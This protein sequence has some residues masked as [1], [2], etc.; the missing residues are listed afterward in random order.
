MNRG[1]LRPVPFALALVSA[2]LALS[3]ASAHEPPFTAEFGRDRCTFATTNGPDAYFPLWPG[4]SLRLEGEEES[5]GEVVELAAI[6]TVL[7]ATELVDG[8]LTRVYEEYETED[9]E[10]TEVSRNFFAV[11]RETGDVWYFGEEVD[12]YED[13]EIVG[14]DGAWRAGVDGAEPG[15]FMPGAPLVGARYFN[16]IAPGIALDQA[17]IVGVDVDLSVPAGD[18]QGLVYT[19]E[20]TTLEPGALSEKWY[21]RGIGFVR[22]DAQ[23]LI[24]VTPPP[25]RPDA[26]THCLRNGRFRVTARWRDFQEGTG[27]GVAILPSGDSGE[28]WFFAPDNSELLVKVLDACSFPGGADYWVF[29]GGLTNV[30]VTLTVTDTQADETRIYVNPLGAPF[31]PILDT[32]AF[33]TCP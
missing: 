5:D 17:E 25:C 12:I 14:H 8:V 30:E 2:F 32:T 28:F 4:Y 11:C 27:D 18:F 26:T 6:H 21:G 10:L 31:A 7:P 15:I 33:A 29:A 1:S 24:E 23:E 19:N 13:G 22:D 3:V 20:T 16:E 9:G